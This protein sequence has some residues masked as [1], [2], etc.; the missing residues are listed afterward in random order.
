MILFF[1]HAFDESD[2]FVKV[3]IPF[4][5]CKIN[6]DNVKVDF[7]ESSFNLTIV[8]DTKD[9]NFYV[10][11]LLKPIVIEKSYRKV[12]DDMVS[13]YLKKSN[14]GSKWEVLTK[15]AKQLKDQ[16]N[17]MFDDD[18]GPKSTEDPMGG[19]MNIMKKMYESGDPEMKRT[20]AKAWTE[21]QE[22]K[23]NSDMNMGF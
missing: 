3:H 10:K 8:G 23:N 12:K 21:G 18:S 2:K 19:L 20:I 22:K 5:Q 14:E 6:D 13:I 4:T 16:K 11:N 17:K 9:Y 15:T 7:T 1:R